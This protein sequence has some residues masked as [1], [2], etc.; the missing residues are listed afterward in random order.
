MKFSG[1]TPSSGNSL[2]QQ[3]MK[4]PRLDWHVTGWFMLIGYFIVQANSIFRQCTPRYVAGALVDA[5]ECKQGTDDDEFAD[6]ICGEMFSMNLCIKRSVV[7]QLL[8]CHWFG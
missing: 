8:S 4:S 1:Q 3:E 7:W 5:A 2:S 6:A